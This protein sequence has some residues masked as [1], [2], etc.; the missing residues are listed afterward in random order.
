M[1]R[2][3]M[4]VMSGVDHSLVWE[5][6]AEGLERAGVGCRYVLMNAGDSPFE[7][8]LRARGIPVSRIRYS[9]KRDAP[10]AVAE[11]AARM[12]RYRPRVVHAHLFDASVLGMVA[13][14]LARVPERIHTRHYSRLQQ[15]YHPNAVK[16][17]RLATRLSTRVVAIS[18]VVADALVDEGAPREKIVTIHHGFDVDRFADVPA[19]RVAVMRAKHDIGGPVVGV[20][21]RYIALKGLD[22]VIP[23]FGAFLSGHPS[24]LLVLANAIGEEKETV[25]RLLA[26]HCPGAHRQIVFETDSPA[27]YKTF[28]FFVHAPIDATCEAF[29]QTYVE[30]LAAGV[31]SVF[32]LSGVAHELVRH[33]HNALVVPHRDAAAIAAALGRLAGDP[34]LRATIAANGLADVRNGFTVERMVAGHV[35]LYERS[36]VS[37]DA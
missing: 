17:D 14:R 34:A 32:A 9:S 16:Y 8:F 27:L 31:P 25:E 20:V 10:R 33:E 21:S 12:V 29:G 7:T 35:A 5:W 6:L 19:E 24:A 15:T 26:Q 1:K 28:D 30:A 37:V 22:F 13:A 3:V 23:A 11:L 4:V 2:P 36:G 18:D